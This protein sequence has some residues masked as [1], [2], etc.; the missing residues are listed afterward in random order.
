MEAGCSYRFSPSPS[1][2]STRSASAESINSVR[3]SASESAEAVSKAISDCLDTKTPAIDH[4]LGGHF[5]TLKPWRGDNM[6][7]FKPNKLTLF[8]FVLLAHVVHKQYLNYTQFGKHCFFFAG[9]VYEATLRYSGVRP[10]N[11]TD[12]NRAD[13]HG[14]WNSVKV[15]EV[16]PQEVSHI[17][18]KFKRVLAKQTVEVSVCLFELFSVTNT[19]YIDRSSVSEEFKI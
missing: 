6:Q 10:S 7:S 12:A 5:V 9:L 2:E 17:V 4:F 14:H 11:K 1:A 3:V 13:D 16:D 8:E 19:I 15:S 18:T